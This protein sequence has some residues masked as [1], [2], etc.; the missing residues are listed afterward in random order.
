[1]DIPCSDGHSM[2][3]A[4][5]KVYVGRPP[6]RTINYRS[7]KTFIEKDFKSDLS[8]VPFSV[9]DVFED[10]GDFLWAQNSLIEEVLNDHAPI[11]T[12]KVRSTTPA[13]MNTALRKNIMNKTRLR[14]RFKRTRL[15]SDWDKYKA[16]RNLTTKIRR[17]SIKEYFLERCQEGPKNKHF[18][19]TI[20][21]FL[22]SKYK[23]DHNLMIMDGTNLL[24][25]PKE[26]F[27]MLQFYYHLRQYQNKL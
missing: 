7:F 21:P 9:C 13:F 19:S 23:C 14:N 2:I 3:L 11:K 16:Q 6:P 26:V 8:K 25:D 17:Q 10:P 15:R 20:K 18:Y 5:T 12:S 1:M 4:T 27:L 22:S 24:T